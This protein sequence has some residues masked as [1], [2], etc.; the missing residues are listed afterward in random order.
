MDAH[1]TQFSPLF[2]WLGRGVLFF[3]RKI[4]KA[5]TVAYLPA[6]RWSQS[7]WESSQRREGQSQETELPDHGEIFEPWNQTGLETSS[8]FNTFKYLSQLIS[9]SFLRLFELDFLWLTVKRAPLPHRILSPVQRC[10]ARAPGGCN[11]P[12]PPGFELRS[13]SLVKGWSV[14]P[15]RTP[16]PLSVLRWSCPK[17]GAKLYRLGI[18][19]DPAILLGPRLKTP[20]EYRQEEKEHFLEQINFWTWHL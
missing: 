3:I 1:M 7:F 6:I 5:R 20:V 12:N 2:T 9:F 11:F 10:G 18:E 8:I 14:L 17:V 19:C 13:V 16:F 4:H 15:L